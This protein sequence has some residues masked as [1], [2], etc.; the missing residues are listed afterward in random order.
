MKMISHYFLKIK[1]KIS[2]IDLVEKINNIN[3]DKV[4]NSTAGVKSLSKPEFVSLFL[5]KRNK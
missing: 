3:F 5:K 2:I 1:D 4:I